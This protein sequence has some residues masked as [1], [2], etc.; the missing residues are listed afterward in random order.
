MSPVVRGKVPAQTFNRLVTLVARECGVRPLEVK[1]TVLF[2]AKSGYE[3]STLQGDQRA[4][5]HYGHVLDRM[6]TVGL[7]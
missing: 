5:A 7:K 1:R 3:A 6:T 2:V 4:K